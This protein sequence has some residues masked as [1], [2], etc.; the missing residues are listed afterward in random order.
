MTDPWLSAQ[1][2]HDAAWVRLVEDLD[3]ALDQALA[4]VL[5]GL[6]RIVLAVPALTAA[7][8]P[9]VLDGRLEEATRETWQQ[10]LTRWVRPILFSAW[11]REYAAARPG[12]AVTAPV[13]AR[14]AWWAATVQKVLP[15]A[16]SLVAAVRQ[17]VQSAPTESIDQLRDRVARTLG[18][19]APSRSKR[20]EIA[21]IE[22]RLFAA[23]LPADVRD[24]LF[25]RRVKLQA[26][27]FE[28]E[29]RD[30]K[31][32]ALSALASAATDARQA[33]EYRR[34]AEKLRGAGRDAAKARSDLSELDAQ[35]YPGEAPD[36]E[37]EQLELRHRRAELYRSAEQDDST[38]QA[39][40]RR[41][42]RTESTN[43]LNA[44][45]LERGRDAE[46]ATGE[47]LVKRWVS[48]R[49]HRV[50]PTHVRANGQVVPLADRFHVGDGFL[51]M[52]GDPEGPLEEVINCRC[53]I[54]VLTADEN[55]QIASLLPDLQAALLNEA[56]NQ[57]DAMSVAA[58]ELGDLPPV[59]WHGVIVVED[60]YTGDRRKFA[61][62]AIR[63]QALPM[64]IRF[65]REDWGG[66][67]G[68][69]VT[70][71]L[72]GARRFGTA[73]RAW[74]TFAD[75]SLTPEVDEVQGLMATR[76][77]RG[78]SIDGDDSVFAPEADA[79]GNM[80]EVYSSLRLR[81]ATFV[82]IPA[83]DEAEVYLGP[84]PDEWYLEGEPVIEEQSAPETTPVDLEELF[85]DANP[86]TGMPARLVAYWTRG[87]GAAKIR[88]G[89]PGDFNRC[90]RNLAEYIPPGQLS[91][92][93]ANLHHRALGVW[94]GREHAGEVLVA[95][96]GVR[97]FRR[98][99]FDPMSDLVPELTPEGF[100]VPVTITDDGAVY[101]YAAVWGTCHTGFSD[102]CIMPPRSATNYALFHVGAVRLEDG[103]DLP[104]GK[105]TVSLDDTNGG[106]A[107]GRAGIGPASAHYDNS[108]AAV[109]VVRAYDN[110]HGIQVVGRIIPG[111][112]EE[113]IAAL[114]RSPLSGDWRE[115]AGNLEMVA[116]LGVNVPGFPVPRAM[117]ASVDGRQVTLI[118]AGRV[119]V[120][121]TVP[122][123]SLEQ[124]TLAAAARV[125]EM[126]V[127][128]D[129]RSA[130]VA[131]AARRINPDEGG[132]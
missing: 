57:E 96:A 20:D 128:P 110:E 66:H 10:A 35:L 21:A 37:D 5:A 29:A 26:R 75:G 107:P 79:E 62:G 25:A 36:S 83:F 89:E 1:Q 71:N 30:A 101:G 95:S 80:Y 127:A 3:A 131:A 87:E 42:A 19:D 84:P 92:A 60:T 93:C 7:G 76:M 11:Q 91:G 40:M 86:G 90:R 82:A 118:A 85:A 98:A 81:A 41:I 132:N 124:R 18:L 2:R 114:R 50:R 119:P 99:D 112:S 120:M 125:A 51:L 121:D 105:L 43:V 109:A 16:D 78:I 34:E 12:Q 52:P 53:S 33:A 56:T 6:W 116:A 117:V 74:G 23:D 49:D 48:A 122:V 39:S 68:A 63:T 126:R 100:P 55:E 104:I 130:R 94:P 129:L 102:V 88:W 113:K 46:Q 24:R 67:T 58:E 123:P 103:T 65:Q 45:T 59:M 4:E 97:P 77:I 17:A 38:W 14:D 69:V 9:P 115:Y 31:R 111:T 27:L 22:A 61:A 13:A 28:A 54:A 32:R 44:A 108:C 72:D 47:P 106:H 73:I 8:D 64:P 15:T 70:A